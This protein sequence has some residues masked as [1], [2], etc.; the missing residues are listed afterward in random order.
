MTDN[1][2]GSMAGKRVLVTGGTGGIGKATATGLAAL[3]ASVGIV[4]PR[5][6]AGAGGRRQ[7]RARVRRLLS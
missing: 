2:T 3:G 5:P 7:Y 6:P 1:T 4:G